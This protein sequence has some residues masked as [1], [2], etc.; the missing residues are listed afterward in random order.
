MEATN[1][2]I[3]TSHVAMVTHPEEVTNLIEKAA[4]G[5]LATR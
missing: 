2:E 4:Q 3:T 5:V 1:E